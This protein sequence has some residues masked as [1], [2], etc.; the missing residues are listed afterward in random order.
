M[1]NHLKCLS[2]KASPSVHPC[3]FLSLKYAL[4]SAGAGRSASSH[5]AGPPP[6]KLQ[7]LIQT[8]LN[9]PQD[10]K[11]Q[12]QTSG[13]LQ[14]AIFNCRP[15]STFFL[16]TPLEELRS[17]MGNKSCS[18][19]LPQARSPGLLALPVLWG[20]CIASCA[21]KLTRAYAGGGKEHFCFSVP[22]TEGTNC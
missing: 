18:L 17:N 14:L 13:S 2:L 12:V 6:Q 7:S 21:I 19:L 11:Q 4:E 10:I 20:S 9:L 16:S 15:L 5:G 22:R 1:Q 8:L 3:S